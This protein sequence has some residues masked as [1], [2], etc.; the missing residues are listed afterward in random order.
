MGRLRRVFDLGHTTTAGVPSV[1]SSSRDLDLRR[2]AS[3]ART[4]LAG[5]R[6]TVCVQLAYRR[7]SRAAAD[8][9]LELVV[10]ARSRL[11]V[12]G[13]GWGVVRDSSGSMETRGDVRWRAPRAAVLVFG[14]GRVVFEVGDE[15]RRGIW[16]FCGMWLIR[17]VFFANCNRLGGW[18]V[19]PQVPHQQI[20][21]VPGTGDRIWAQKLYSV[22]VKLYS[23]STMTE[24]KPADK[25]ED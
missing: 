21:K 7:P 8:D 20:H 13:N 19:L 24:V 11:L 10:L 18:H 6:D 4:R 5:R 14:R 25:F 15:G 2:A 22:T 1:C 9:G 23:Q 17:W 12:E 16:A 3:C